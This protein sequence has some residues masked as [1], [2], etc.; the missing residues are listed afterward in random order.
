MRTFLL[1]LVPFLLLKNALFVGA[2]SL[3]SDD[4]DDEKDDA[5]F[6]LR[7]RGNEL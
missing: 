6:A 2:W 3:D 7:R 1:F 4:V 5:G